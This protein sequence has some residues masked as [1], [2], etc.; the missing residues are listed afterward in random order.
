MH[1][2]WQRK[3]TSIT[4]RKIGVPKTK[5]ESG[6][7]NSLNT[8]NL[9]NMESEDVCDREKKHEFEYIT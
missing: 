9:Q 8:L 4:E 1:D 3:S 6:K 2:F 7:L 5:R